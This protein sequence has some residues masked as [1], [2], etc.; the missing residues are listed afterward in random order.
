MLYEA[1]SEHYDY[2]PNNM[3]NY[4]SHFY[5]TIVYQPDT[6]EITDTIHT[7]TSSSKSSRQYYTQST[8][9]QY[10]YESSV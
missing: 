2:P 4:S 5:N 6:T 9:S 8:R 3:H 10:H 1:S 7:D